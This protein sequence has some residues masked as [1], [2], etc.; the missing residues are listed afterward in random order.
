M[1]ILN[2]TYHA[3]QASVFFQTFIFQGHLP[4]MTNSPE[5]KAHKPY[6]RDPPASSRPQT[7]S[8]LGWPW[9]R[10]VDE[11]CEDFESWG[12][13]P[14]GVL[15]FTNSQEAMNPL[16]PPRQSRCGLL[17]NWNLRTQLGFDRAPLHF[18]FLSIY[19]PPSPNATDQSLDSATIWS[20]Y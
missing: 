13:L 15:A 11:A 12:H 20:W 17:G 19:S 7:Q 18:A 4:H 8:S 16:W 1:D 9:R 3:H 2:V 10:C 6:L 5:S 14:L